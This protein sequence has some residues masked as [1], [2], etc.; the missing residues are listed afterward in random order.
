MLKINIELKFYS[1]KCIH[2]YVGSLKQFSDDENY[3]TCVYTI[4]K[5]SLKPFTF[6]IYYGIVTEAG[7]INL[8]H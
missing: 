3:K 6:I 7:M 5:K 4:L 1:S 8:Q 2:I